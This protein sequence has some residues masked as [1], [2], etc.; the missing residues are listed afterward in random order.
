MTDQ[1]KHYKFIYKGSEIDTKYC[2]SREAGKFCSE[3]EEMNEME[4]HS[5]IISKIED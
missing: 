1:K 5:I 2:T 3:L 4:A